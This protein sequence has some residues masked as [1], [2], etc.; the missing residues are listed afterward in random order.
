LFTGIVEDMGRIVGSEDRAG[1]R[2]LSLE[3]GSAAKELQ[4]DGVRLD[5]GTLYKMTGTP[6][7]AGKIAFDRP[8][9]PHKN[10]C[11]F[12]Y[13]ANYEIWGG[14]MIPGNPNQ[15]V[16]VEGDILKINNKLPVYFGKLIESWQP[17]VEICPTISTASKPIWCGE[18]QKEPY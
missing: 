13:L 18:F 11:H 10:G 12:K 9:L 1:Q 17:V 2:T 7:F 5:D 6:G 4:L 14:K 15:E 8:Q 16:M 3:A